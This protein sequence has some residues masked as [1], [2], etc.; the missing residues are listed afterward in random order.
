MTDMCISYPN[1]DRAMAETL[2][3]D[4]VNRGIDASL[5]FARDAYDDLQYVSS[6]R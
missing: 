3:S 5:S 1:A 2:A 4:F 6:P